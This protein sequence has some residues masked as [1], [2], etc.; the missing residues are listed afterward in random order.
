MSRRNAFANPNSERRRTSASSRRNMAA[1]S[2]YRRV[3]RRT[4]RA[5]EMAEMSE[6]QTDWPNWIVPGAISSMMLA[7][8]LYHH[9]ALLSLVRGAL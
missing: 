6:Q 2:T 3:P 8:T 5:G 4:V 9:G 7:I 1:D